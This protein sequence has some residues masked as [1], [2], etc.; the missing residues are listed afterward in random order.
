MT[1]KIAALLVFLAWPLQALADM[2]PYMGLDVAASSGHI[3]MT[4]VS[5]KRT[6][7]GT[8]GMLGGAFIGVGSLIVPHFWLAGE[9]MGDFSSSRS[10][11]K[12]IRAAGHAS[13]GR[14]RAR[15]G[16]TVSLI[17]GYRFSELF[18]LYARFGI[19]QTRFA[20]TQSVPPATASGST[21]SNP[22]GG[23]VFGVGV[24]FRLGPAFHLRGEYDREV[25]RHFT[26]FG[27]RAMPVE[28]QFHLG[29]LYDFGG[30]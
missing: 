20:Y 4:D 8:S 16:Y 12:N 24:Q 18:M 30:I 14:F 22:V 3:S 19:G 5:G 2:H 6:G 10:G 21:D 26:T 15:Y 25:Y 7:F 11:T 27:N 28:N 17:P 29:L 23:A 1:R 13:T 9:V